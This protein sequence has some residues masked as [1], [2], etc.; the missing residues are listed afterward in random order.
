MHLQGILF[1]GHDVFEFDFV[2]LYKD[3]LP[4]L[5]TKFQVALHIMQILN[6][7]FGVCA[8]IYF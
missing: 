6:T 3:C 8:V 5:L 7:K 2:S 1:K 4:N